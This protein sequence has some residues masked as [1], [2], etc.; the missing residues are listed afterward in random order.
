MNSTNIATAIQTEI[1]THSSFSECLLR[2][3]CVLC[4]QLRQL[5]VF[6][7]SQDW[8]EEIDEQ[9][10][11]S[12]QWNLTHHYLSNILVFLTEPDELSQENSSNVRSEGLW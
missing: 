6:S 10:D 2:T 9:L 12:D 7:Q 3:H 1:F 4:F 8:E 11:V 5:P